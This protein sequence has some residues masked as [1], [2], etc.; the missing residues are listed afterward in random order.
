MAPGPKRWGRVEEI[1][2]LALEQPPESREQWLD[3]TCAGDRTLRI[4]VASLLESDSSAR[5]G[6]VGEKVQGAIRD[7]MDDGPPFSTAASTS[8]SISAMEGRLIGHWRLIREIGRGGMGSVYLAARADQQY[9]SNV[10]VKLVRPGW[11]TD[12]MLQRFRRE[13]QILARFDHPN[14]T[15]LF[16]GGSTAEGVPYLVMEYIEG[17]AITRY[18]AEHRLSIEE[19]IRL[20]LPVCAAVEYAHRNFIVHRD[21]KPANILI[22]QT[23]VPKLLDFGI[24]KLL[25]AD[26]DEPANTQGGGLL[27]PEYASPEQIL[28]EP[29][30]IASDLYS[31]GAVMYELLTGV[32]PHRVER[33][34]VIDL[35]RAI[36]Q[37]PLT[38]PSKAATDPAVARG[39]RGDLDNILLRA[40]QKEPSRRYAS[41]ERFSDDLRRYLEHRPVA[42]RPDSLVYRASKF[43]R[44]NRLAVTLATLAGTAILAGAAI[45]VREARIANERFQ[46]VRKLAT[47]FVFDVEESVRNLPGATPVRQLIARTGTKYLDSL[48]RSSGGD[49]A[50]KRELAGSYL[51]VA[52]VKGGM[53]TGNLGDSAG[54]MASYAS[55]GKLL[56]EVL[57]HSGSDHLAVLER[58]DVYL[59][60]SGLQNTS[61]QGAD[62]ASLARAGLRLTQT[63]LKANP[64]D[65]E[66]IRRA[67]L[68]HSQLCTYYQLSG[69]VNPAE[70]E[71]LASIQLLQKYADAKP[72]DRDAQM[73]LANARTLMGGVEVKLGRPK[74]AL[75]NYRDSAAIMGAL[76]TKYPHDTEVRRHSMMSYASLSTLLVGPEYPEVVDL[77]GAFEA[78]K[79]MVEQAK[80][81]YDADPADVRALSDYAIAD[82]RLGLV[83]PASG[84]GQRQTFEV[85]HELLSRAAIQNPQDRAVA[86]SKSEVETRLAMIYLAQGDRAAGTRYYQ[87]A[88]A[89]GEKNVASDPTYYPYVDRLVKAVRGLA[90]EQAR[91]GGRTEA[92]ATL[93]RGLRITKS[94]EASAPPNAF[95]LHVVIA[96]SWGA[97]GSVYAILSGR[98]QGAQAVADRAAAR[99]WYGRSLEGWHK[100][101]SQKGFRLTFRQ[102]MEA[103]EKALAQIGTDKAKS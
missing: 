41:V 56:D 9:E 60:E 15:R 64:N 31:L 50:L 25:Q 103:T 27:T 46:D 17:I 77:Q 51:R 93:G 28:G 84:P 62:A 63:L 30:T 96:R 97:A 89:T 87:M 36:C 45:S 102:E 79:K 39:L 85:A 99:E 32:R 54:A 92:L 86:G 18:A 53:T 94:T 57:R 44:R 20:C 81:L 101:E 43:I 7:L 66:A 90:Q 100:L 71:G 78:G 80:F 8:A 14:I 52:R 88:I 33:G 65:L 73:D 61:M 35:Q 10:A 24:S 40:M 55:A 83:T 67:G 42:A 91:V 48:A 12:S 70:P 72:G 13:R 1:F 47:T 69:N 95:L 58:V 75:A 2:H 11:D 34:S 19:R 68:L 6:F 74:D 21:L 37:E 38:P 29:V 76:N 22:D 23:G 59:E 4:E 3:Q 98:E 26:P 49:W 5:Q 16:D 82:F